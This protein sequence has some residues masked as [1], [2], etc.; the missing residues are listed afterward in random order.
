MLGQ[1][2]TLA[3]FSQDIRT[4]HS[5]FVCWMFGFRVPHSAFNCLHPFAARLSTLF[6]E[7]KHIKLN[8]PKEI[9]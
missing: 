3:T 8:R 9:P 1:D 2:D 7:R 6:R 4:P 5:A